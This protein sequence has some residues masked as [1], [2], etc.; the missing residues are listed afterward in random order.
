VA[1]TVRLDH[2]LTHYYDGDWAVASRRELTTLPI[3]EVIDTS[4]DPEWSGGNA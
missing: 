2:I 4:L 3:R 1:A